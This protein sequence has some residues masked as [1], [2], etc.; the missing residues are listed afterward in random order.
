[1][2]IVDWDADLDWDWHS[3][4]E[5]TPEQLLTLWQNAVKRSRSAVTE[6]LDDGGLERLALHT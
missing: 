6:A 4:A 2:D 1:M 5:D 3:A